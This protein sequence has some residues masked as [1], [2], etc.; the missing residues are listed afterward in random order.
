M[1]NL[2]LCD[3]YKYYKEEKKVKITNIQTSYLFVYRSNISR[4]DELK[5][6]LD[7]NLKKLIFFLKNYK[8]DF[9]FIFYDEKIVI[10]SS[11]V[12]IKKNS[13]DKF[14]FEFQNNSYGVIGPVYTNPLYRGKQFYKFALEMQINNLIIEHTIDEIFISTKHAK[15]VLTPFKYNSLKKFSSGIILSILDKLFIYIVYKKPFKI[16]IFLNDNLIFKLK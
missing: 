2:T 4:L 7:N 16:R 8:I 6:N 11:G 3:L 14:F 13:P 15:K 5:F 1:L 10:H 12:S 9:I